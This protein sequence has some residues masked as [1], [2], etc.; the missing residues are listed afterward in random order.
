MKPVSNDLQYPE[1]KKT[2][3]SLIFNSLRIGD[4][5]FDKPKKLWGFIA[6]TSRDLG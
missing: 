4:L 3:I 6:W 1:K 5:V 2:S